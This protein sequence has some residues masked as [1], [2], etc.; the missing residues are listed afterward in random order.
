MACFSTSNVFERVA[1]LEQS[2]EEAR[3]E[4]KLM[5]IDAERALMLAQREASVIRKQQR[6]GY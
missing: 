5:V 6:G 1:M 2:L 4:A 3:F